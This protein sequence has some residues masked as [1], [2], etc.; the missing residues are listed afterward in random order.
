MFVSD[1]WTKNKLFKENKG[2]EATKTIL[3]GSFW[4]SVKDILMVMAPLVRVLRLVDGEKR[5]AMDYIYE[6]M[7]KAK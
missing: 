2:K 6:A 7:E 5:P 1:D 3:M 4:D